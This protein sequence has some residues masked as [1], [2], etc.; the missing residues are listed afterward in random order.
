[1]DGELSRT[2]L[3]GSREQHRNSQQG[4]RERGIR[5]ALGVC[6]IETKVAA[7]DRRG[8]DCQVSTL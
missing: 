7:S 6:E 3:V 2:R 1:M 4:V 5:A 8:H